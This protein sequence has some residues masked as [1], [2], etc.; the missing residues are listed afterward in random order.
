MNARPR[1]GMRAASLVLLPLALAACHS[2]EKPG[3]GVQGEILPAS[4]SDAMLPLDT[5][6][7]QPPLV[8][9]PAARSAGEGGVSAE[10]ASDAAQGPTQGEATPAAGESSAPATTAAARPDEG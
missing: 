7:S 2:E 10:A 6:R 9:P 5:V 1:Q 4:V 3:G 8:A